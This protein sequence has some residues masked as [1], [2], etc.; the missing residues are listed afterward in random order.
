MAKSKKVA[1]VAPKPAQPKDHT[2]LPGD[3]PSLAT[4]LQQLGNTRAY[5]VI[6]SHGNSWRVHFEGDFKPSTVAVVK[7]KWAIILDK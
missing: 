3:A 2:D 4:V 6:R 1:M 5:T 7:G